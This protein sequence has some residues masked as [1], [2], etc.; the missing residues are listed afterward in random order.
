MTISAEKF[1]QIG[2]DEVAYVKPVELDDK[3]IAYAVHAA[4]GTQLSI[5]DSYALAVASVRHH[6][7]H[8]V[9]VH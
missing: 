7:M 4:D 2:L 5:L 6:D 8:P 1:K 9:T 3:Q